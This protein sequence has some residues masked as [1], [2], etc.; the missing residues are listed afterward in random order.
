MLYDDRK[1]EPKKR[2]IL[3]FNVTIGNYG[4]IS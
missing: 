2:A 3:L 4:K 1:S